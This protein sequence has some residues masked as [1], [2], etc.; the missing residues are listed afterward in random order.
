M[1]MMFVEVAYLVCLCCLAL[2][3]ALDLVGLAVSLHL[4]VADDVA[5]GLLHVAVE[6]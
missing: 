1:C 5:Y 3:C 6:E 4:L 2:C